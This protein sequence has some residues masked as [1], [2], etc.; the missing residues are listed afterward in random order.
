MKTILL[1][2]VQLTLFCLI[3]LRCQAQNRIVGG[4]C[5]G[6]EALLEHGE[7][8]LKPIDTLPAFEQN[9][10]RLKISGTVYHR[11]GKTP[12]SAVIIYIY[13]TNRA[14]VYETTGQEKG[15][16]RRHGCIRGWTKT[17]EQGGYTF[18]TFRP[19][20]Y[21]DHSEPEHI[22]ITIKEPDTNAYYLD[23]FLFDDDPLLSSSIRARQPGRGGSGIVIPIQSGDLWLIERNIVLGL[24]IPD[25]D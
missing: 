9:N 22:H 23:D 20:A 4:G 2:G 17:D 6:C 21:P 12:A 16:A 19:A 3:T 15:W 11:D 13:H 7:K 18:Y 14:G 25:Y 1:T 8:T 24:N 5:E 10:P